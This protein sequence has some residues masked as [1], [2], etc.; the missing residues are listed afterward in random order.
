[1]D[2]LYPAAVVFV[3]LKEAGMECERKRNVTGVEGHSEFGG[4]VYFACWI[5]TKLHVLL[6]VCVLIKLMA[7][8][9]QVGIRTPIAG[10][11][12]ITRYLG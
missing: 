10:T 8:D 7:G 2:S 12:L 1:V 3:L 6:Q 5:D 9:G 4:G 11:L